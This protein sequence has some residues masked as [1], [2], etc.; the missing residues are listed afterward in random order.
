VTKPELY[1]LVFHSSAGREVLADLNGYVE[2]MDVA[3]PGSAAKILAHIHHQLY[4]PDAPAKRSPV[5][6][7]ASGGR[8]A[9]G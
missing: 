2:R 3:Q 5:P 4:K 9:H 1:R 7:K 8:I 6:L